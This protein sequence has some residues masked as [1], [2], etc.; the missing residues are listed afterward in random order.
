LPIEGNPHFRETIREVK[1]K[2]PCEA[3]MLGKPHEGAIWAC[4]QE[5]QFRV[6]KTSLEVSAKTIHAEKEAGVILGVTYVWDATTGLLI[7]KF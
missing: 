7:R 6:I 4:P 5:H 2:C 1:F 3:F